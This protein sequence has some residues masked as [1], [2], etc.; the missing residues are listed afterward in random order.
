MAKHR[1]E[2]RM[3]SASNRARG[4]CETEQKFCGPW[5][6]SMPEAETDCAKHSRQPGNAKH[7]M[8]VIIETR[9]SLRVG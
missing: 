2:N 5:R 9:F 3:A 4:Y 8:R 1:I 6:A 7:I